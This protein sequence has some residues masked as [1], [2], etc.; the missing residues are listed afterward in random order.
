LGEAYDR[1]SYLRKPYS[2]E[3]RNAVPCWSLWGCARWL[4]PW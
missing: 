2:M 4:Q 1:T 3:S